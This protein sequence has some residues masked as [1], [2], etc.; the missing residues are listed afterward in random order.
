M[1]VLMSHI[2]WDKVFQQVNRSVIRCSTRYWKSR[3]IPYFPFLFLHLL[4]DTVFPSATIYNH[5]HFT[6]AAAP[7]TT[8]AFQF[9]LVFL[10][11]S[12]PLLSWAIFVS[13]N[14]LLRSTLWLSHAFQGGCPNSAFSKPK[15]MISPSSGKANGIWQPPSAKHL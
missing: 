1:L 2:H 7:D 4:S 11:I 8:L 3:V 13:F 9:S 15:G 5:F 14:P 6:P 10:Y 12:F